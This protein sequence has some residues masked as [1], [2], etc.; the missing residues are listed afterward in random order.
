MQYARVL[1]SPNI[2]G[3]SLP[4]IP[5]VPM[6]PNSRLLHA[7]LIRA[8]RCCSNVYDFNDE[9]RRTK[10]TYEFLGLSNA[11]VEQC[12]GQ[13]LRQFG[14]PSMALPISDP[15][16]YNSLRNRIIELE[17][18]RVAWSAQRKISRKHKFI[19]QYPTDWDA[20]QVSQ[21]RHILEETF[22][23]RS[24]QTSGSSNQ[25]FEM[26]PVGTQQLSTNDFLVDKRPPMHLLKLAK[27]DQIHTSTY[28]SMSLTWNNT[29]QTLL[30]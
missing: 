2:H 16:D 13:F 7:A 28:H 25:E 5:H 10:L 21:L 12:L 14:S 26:K 6:C 9:D 27:S 23:D 17:Q 8:A 24:E 11:F 15:I 4:D 22:Q 18:R 20:A 3:N 30:L 1:A 29:A 19:F